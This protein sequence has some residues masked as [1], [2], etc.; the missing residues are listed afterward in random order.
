MVEPSKEEFLRGLVPA[1]VRTQVYGTLLDSL[2]AEHG[3]R[4][5][6]MQIASE[7]AEEMI[8]TITQQYNKV[9]QEVITNEILDIVGG[10]EALRNK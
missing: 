7:N 9:R 2:T 3:A 10:S 4:T 8:S 6:A 5:T 1:V